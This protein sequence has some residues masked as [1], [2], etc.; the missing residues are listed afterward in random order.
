MFACQDL[1]R[2]NDADLWDVKLRLAP[3]MRLAQTVR[4]ENG[5][6]MAD[7]AK[8]TF[9]D[10]FI[11]EYDVEPRTAGLLI[12]YDGKRSSEEVL[13]RLAKEMGEEAEDMREGWMGYL[14]HLIGSGIVEP[15]GE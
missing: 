9:V 2:M 3:D 12:L 11:Q 8:L 5:R 4:P 14:R 1:L 10:G 15:A 7:S 13:A 6:W